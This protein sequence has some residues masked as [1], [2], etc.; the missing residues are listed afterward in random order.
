METV[1][2]LSQELTLLD[3]DKHEFVN[4]GHRRDLLYRLEVDSY[5]TASTMQ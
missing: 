3:V 5:Y 4:L 2:Q 1:S